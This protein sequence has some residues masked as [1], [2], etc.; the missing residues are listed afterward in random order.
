MINK[1]E[2]QTRKL[3][4]KWWHIFLGFFVVIIFLPLV[5][6][7]L[8][9][10]HEAVSNSPEQWGQFGDYIGGVLNPILGFATFA[11][12]LYTI[13]LQLDTIRLQQ[14]S[15]DIQQEELEASRAELA[16]G[17]KA[18]RQAKKV[19]AEQSQIFRG[20]Q[21]EATFFSMLNQLSHVHGRLVDS[22]HEVYEQLN[23]N[24]LNDYSLEHSHIAAGEEKLIFEKIKL[25][26]FSAIQNCI[27]KNCS[28]FNQFSLLLYQVLKFISVVPLPV[29]EIRIEQEKRYSNIVRA[30]IDF[31]IL[32]I[33]A[34]S[35][36]RP[37]KE[38]YKPYQELF[39]KYA[40]LEHM[41]FDISGDVNLLLVKCYQFYNIKAFGNNGYLTEKRVRDLL[42]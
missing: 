34:L 37:N 35:V 31:R 21:F 15:L 22:I 16:R 32:Q 25:G 20:Q 40:F 28:E 14:Y 36:Y 39:E 11:A 23:A 4:I 7:L 13:K 42:S 10:G 8:K 41:P 17:A 2:A 1:Q 33:L 9:F 3:T 27:D 5:L 26:D 30:L 24:G 29:N 38:S 6:Y 18:Q 19:L 12:L